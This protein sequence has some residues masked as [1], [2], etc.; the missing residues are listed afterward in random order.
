[1]FPSRFFVAVG[2]PDIDIGHPP[3]SRVFI[4]PRAARKNAFLPDTPK[5]WCNFMFEQLA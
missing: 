4:P 3:T 1:M 5:A 2:Y